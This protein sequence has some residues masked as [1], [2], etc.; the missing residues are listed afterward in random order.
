MKVD[1]NKLPIIKVKFC[2]CLKNAKP[3]ELPAKL[4]RTIE[5]KGKLHHCAADAYEAMDAAANAEGIDLSPTSQADTYRSLEVQEYG[6][7][8]RYTDNPSPAIMKQKPRIYKNKTWYLKK[9]NGTNGCAGNK[10]P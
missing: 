8:Q 7:Y 5:G 10:Q 1:V 9:R 6:F 4:L 2:S 3:G